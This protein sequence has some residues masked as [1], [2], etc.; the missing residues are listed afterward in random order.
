MVETARTGIIEANLKIYLNSDVTAEEAKELL[1]EA[2][3]SIRHANIAD[4]EI[5]SHDAEERCKEKSWNPME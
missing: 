1:D 5:T 2:I 3:S 4:V